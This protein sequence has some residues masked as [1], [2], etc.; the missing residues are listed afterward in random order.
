MCATQP[1]P[2]SIPAAGIQKKELKAGVRLPL[3]EHSITN[4]RV[5][6]FKNTCIKCLRPAVAA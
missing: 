6:M 1:V 4:R 2:N 5:N 3:N